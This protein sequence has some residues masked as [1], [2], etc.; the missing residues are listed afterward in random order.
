MQCL[1]VPFVGGLGWVEP[2]HCFVPCRLSERS[3]LWPGCL[4]EL[5]LKIINQ[6][7]QTINQKKAINTQKSINHSF[8]SIQRCLKS[9]RKLKRRLFI[10]ICLHNVVPSSLPIKEHTETYRMARF[11]NGACK[12]I[13]ENLATNSKSKCVGSAGPFW[14]Q[15][16]KWKNEIINKLIN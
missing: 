9:L 8:V 7:I 15:I 13:T 4:M 2:G 10:A 1:N 11:Q 3:C 5:D 14:P 6:Q 16:K 12:Q